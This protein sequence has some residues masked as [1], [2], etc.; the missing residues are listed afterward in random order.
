MSKRFL[1]LLLVV[2][3]FLLTGAIIWSLGRQR[4]PEKILKEKLKGLE[5]GETADAGDSLVRPDTTPIPEARIAYFMMDS[6]QKNYELVQESAA[7]VRSEGQRMEGNLQR[8]MQKAQARYNELV[9]KDHTYSTQAEL[10][11]D[12]QEVEQL[13]GKIQQLQADLQEQFDHLQARTLTEIASRI[14]EFLE[15]YN[16]TAGFD[17]IFSIQEAGQIWVGN[18]GLDIT[19]AVVKGLNDQHR[20]RKAAN[21]AAK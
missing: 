6:V 3:N 1:L 21:K 18:K 17:Y 12:Q 10:K 7:R 2:W 8:E 13:G 9:A 11:A 5:P 16:K 4:V 19:P 14:Q 20:A 15:E